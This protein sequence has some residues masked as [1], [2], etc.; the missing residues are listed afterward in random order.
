MLK[1][2]LMTMLITC[3][4]TAAFSQFKL[5]GQVRDSNNEVLPG[6]TVR[7]DGTAYAQATDMRGRFIFN[8]LPQGN[9]VVKVSYVGFETQT[10]EISLSADIFLDFKLEDRVF[11]TDEVIVRST[12]ADSN[13]P[14]AFSSLD[15]EEIRKQNFGQDL[16]MLLNWQPSVVTTSDAGAGVG[17]TGMWI[18]GSD[19]TRINVTI[20]GVPLNDSE[21]QGV[22]WVDIPDIAS[23]TENLQIQRGV[24]TSTNGAGAFGASV[25][26]QTNTVKDQPYADVINAI[27]SFN[28]RRHTAAFG[29]GL[30]GQGWT[31]DGRFSRIES[32]GFID[33]ASADLRAYYLAAGYYGKKSMLKAIMFGGHEVTYQAWY[34]VPQSRLNNDTEAMQRTAEA[35]GWSA[36]QLENLLNSNSRTFNLYT[37]PNQ[38]DDYAQ[39]H[40]QLHYSHRFNEVLTANTAL[41]Y[42]Y[43]RGFYEQFRENDRLSRYGLDNVLIGNTTISRTDLVRRRWLDNDFYG[44]TY[45]LHYDKNKLS[46]MLGG[47]WNRYVGDHFGEIIWSQ[48]ALNFDKDHRYYYNLGDKR[49]FNIYWKNNYQIS[50]KLNAFVDLQI[51]S[52]AYNV[53]G[54]DNNRVD[55]GV[56]VNYNFFNPKFGLSYAFDNQNVWYASYSIA[57]REPVRRDFID[58]PNA[59]TPLPETLRDTE[60][61]FRRNTSGYSL[62]INYY[63]MDYV[64]QLVLTGALNDVGAAIRTNADRSIRT[65]IEL[66]FQYQLS[67]RWSW[68]ANLSLSRN[69]IKEFTEVLY[70]YG[71]NFDDFIV[72]ENLYKNT[73]ISFSPSLIS[74]SILSFK[75]HKNV[76]LTLLSKY[77]GRQYLDN[78]SN[79]DRSIGAYFVNDWRMIYTWHPK[80]VKGIDFS[81]LVNNLFNVEYE[82][83][84]Y[85]Y[86]Y[87]GGAQAY[88]ENFYY[89]QAGI[90]F[91]SS[92]SIRF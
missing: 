20:N 27:G 7:V 54:I 37:Y 50:E 16:P 9:Y 3:S 52:I 55:I 46:S 30:I 21:S 91:M 25:N 56:D 78:T 67:N 35:E 45:S 32:D 18:R 64:N 24:G 43:G 61:G 6:A 84:G 38:V 81:L 85:T 12:R 72:I 4:F 66:D 71:L 75:P 29:T 69:R 34:G 77:V 41:H 1:K 19:Q 53:E 17:Y 63:Y 2:F 26:L 10:E 68:A 90:N 60:I 92:V 80:F 58:A 48:V 59:T 86:G 74:G 87:F 23:S 40:Y 42:T 62:N 5:S 14:A 79:I 31:V 28:T 36:S 33:R 73:D 82:S 89:P 76:E 83:N 51:R 44:V 22:F 39:D 13:T 65:G 88:R 49:D 8:N 70:D 47:A 15:R 11:V 57:N